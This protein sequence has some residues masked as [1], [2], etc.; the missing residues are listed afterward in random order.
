MGPLCLI[1][2]HSWHSSPDR[3]GIRAATLLPLI[4]GLRLEFG[5]LFE[6]YLAIWLDAKMAMICL[7][8]I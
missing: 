8:R 3:A 1:L 2:S 4:L 7:F 5:L 6:Y